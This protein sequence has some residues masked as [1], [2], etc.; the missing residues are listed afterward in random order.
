MPIAGEAD[1]VAT[2]INGRWIEG[3]HPAH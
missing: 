2:C 1:K 3:Y